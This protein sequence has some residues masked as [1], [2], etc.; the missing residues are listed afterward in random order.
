LEKRQH[1]KIRIRPIIT[2]SYLGGFDVTAPKTCVHV[3]FFWSML[4]KKHS[5]KVS[6]IDTATTKI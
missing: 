6:F 4:K 5:S 1:L 2:K 3:V